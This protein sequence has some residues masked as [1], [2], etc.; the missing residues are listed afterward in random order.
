MKS[1]TPL[2]WIDM[3]QIS[4]KARA[5]SSVARRTQQWMVIYHTILAIPVPPPYHHHTLV[6]LL[7]LLYHTIP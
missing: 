7:G 4:V 1:L 2:L 3:K 6:A 5:L